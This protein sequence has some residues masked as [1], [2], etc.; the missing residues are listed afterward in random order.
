MKEV[1]VVVLPKWVFRKGSLN[2]QLPPLPLTTASGKPML[3][4]NS[5]WRAAISS[6]ALDAENELL[7]S[8][9][10]FCKNE[11]KRTLSVFRQSVLIIPCKPYYASAY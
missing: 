6:N 7:H 5:T 8:C 2:D 1:I 4:C 11:E 3:V 9:S 10:A